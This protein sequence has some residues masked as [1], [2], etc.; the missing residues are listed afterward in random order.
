MYESFWYIELEIVL[1]EAG[2]EF[3]LSNCCTLPNVRGFPGTMRLSLTEGNNE[4]PKSTSLELRWEIG[5]TG[6]G[7]KEVS[8]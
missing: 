4:P 1:L 8:P 3:L 7:G 5:N 6:S 2:G